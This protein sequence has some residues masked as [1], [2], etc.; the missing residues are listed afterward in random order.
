MTE[1]HGMHAGKHE[2]HAGGLA[3]FAPGRPRAKGSTRSFRH[4]KTGAQITLGANPKS[5]AWQGVVACAALEAGATPHAGPVC[6]TVT[7][8]FA[9]PKSHYGTGRN[10]AKLK[11]SAPPCPTSRHIG[12]LD[13]L[14][15]ALLDGLTGVAYLDDD[16]VVGLTAAKAWRQEGRPEGAYVH[17]AP[18][19]PPSRDSVCL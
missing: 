4:A 7:F 2:T 3:F 11:G 16:Q 17:V 6:L 15:R 9:R 13:K 12:D 5:K 18:Y 19:V 8:T 10:S 14:T 1:T